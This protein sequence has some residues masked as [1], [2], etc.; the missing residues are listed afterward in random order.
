MALVQSVSIEL[1]QT[2]ESL[3]NAKDD[4]VLDLFQTDSNFSV[5]V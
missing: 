1:G 4:Q 2:F 3:Y 5:L